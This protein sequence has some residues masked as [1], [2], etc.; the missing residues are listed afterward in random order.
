[1]SI[2]IQWFTM[3]DS[4]VGHPVGFPMQEHKVDTN[5]PALT[6]MDD[7]ADSCGLRPSLSATLVVEVAVTLVVVV[8]VVEGVPRVVDGVVE[9][10]RASINSERSR[11][12]FITVEHLTGKFLLQNCCAGGYAPTKAIA[13]L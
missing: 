1:M 2:A 4:L 5:D 11:F 10:A 7:H 3:A 8:V 12:A 13:M 9:S 6:W